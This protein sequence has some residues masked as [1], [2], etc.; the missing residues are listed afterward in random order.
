MKSFVSLRNMGVRWLSHALQS[1]RG[2]ADH[3]ATDHPDRAIT[4]V[5]E[6]REKTELLVDFPSVGRAGRVAG[7][8]ELVVHKNYIIVY[9]MKDENVEIIRVHH[10]AQ[11]H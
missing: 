1:L 2:I 11:K 3:I 6:I 5:R 10:V 7:T 9:R 8:R 4:F